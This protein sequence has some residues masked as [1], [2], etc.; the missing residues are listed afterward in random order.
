MGKASSGN[1]NC[2]DPYMFYCLY[3]TV[4]SKVLVTF[5]MLFCISEI[6]Y[7]FTILNW[8]FLHGNSLSQKKSEALG[9]LYWRLFIHSDLPTIFRSSG[10]LKC[11]QPTCF[12]FKRC[13]KYQNR[14]NVWF[15]L[16]NWKCGS[17]IWECGCL[18]E[19]RGIIRRR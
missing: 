13:G 11:K 19:E 2:I 18:L 10:K 12:V 15:N 6:L 17:G 5:F 9:T 8:F 14:L 16:R 4:N 7:I 1:F 3:W